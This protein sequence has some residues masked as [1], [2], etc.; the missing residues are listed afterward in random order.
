VLGYV[1]ILLII[2]CCC[3]NPLTSNYSCKCQKF[4]VFFKFLLVFVPVASVCWNPILYIFNCN[5]MYLVV[6]RQRPFVR[7]RH[8]VI[9]VNEGRQ[10]VFTCEADGVPLPVVFWTKDNVPLEASSHVSLQL[11]R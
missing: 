10:I 4:E 8:K 9:R 1:F 11:K 7:L 5:A 6:V 2:D 3:I